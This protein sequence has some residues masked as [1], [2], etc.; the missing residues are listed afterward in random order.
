MV[1]NKSLVIIGVVLASFLIAASSRAANFEKTNYVTMDR[2]TALPGVVLAPGTY[3][4]EAIEGHPDIVRVT[5]RATN[6]VL[7]QGFT[8]LVPRPAGLTGVLALGEASGGAPL[9][10]KAWFPRGARSGNAFRHR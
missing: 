3:V 6:R 4:F 8:D 10:I 7:Y 9:P 1:K 5:N 2:P